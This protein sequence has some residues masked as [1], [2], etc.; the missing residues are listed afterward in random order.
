MNARASIRAYPGLSPEEDVRVFVAASR[1]LCSR[2]NEAYGEAE[3]FAFLGAL[4][5]TM[6]KLKTSCLSTLYELNRSPYALNGDYKGVR[7]A[8]FE[9]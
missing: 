2:L 4:L 3:M 5:M 6:E 8:C 1:Q 7:D 9:A